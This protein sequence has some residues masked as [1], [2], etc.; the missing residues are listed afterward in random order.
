[1]AADELFVD[2]SAWYA[3]AVRNDASHDAV[4]HAL[5]RIMRGNRRLVT[6][7]LVI[8]ESHRLLMRRVHRRAAL[9]FLEAVVKPPHVI[10]S[11]TPERE[12]RAQHDWLAPYEDHD[13]SFTDAVSFAVMSERR[14]RSAL[15][16]DGHFRAAG[17]A[18]VPAA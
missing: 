11:S 6:T 8:A 5:R 13:F 3:L 16:L 18:M 14:I 15:T 9:A 4:V 2:T 7:N 1:M 10:V 12:A 17:F